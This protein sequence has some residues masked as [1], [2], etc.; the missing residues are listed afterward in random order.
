MEHVKQTIYRLLQ[1]TLSVA[2][3]LPVA[4]R[5]K[6]IRQGL[7]NIQDYCATFEKTFI[8]HE[9]TITCDQYGL[10]GC[11]HHSATLFRGPNE[12][13][14]VAICVTDQG[15]LLHR[16]DSP[17]TVYRDAGDVNPVQHALATVGAR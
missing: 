15:S 8:F 6:F 7:E 14:S 3:K 10:G 4:K 1:E 17:W 13:A 11:Q 2:Q 16:N 5:R 9:L 12:D